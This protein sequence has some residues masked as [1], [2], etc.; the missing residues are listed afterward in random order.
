[1]EINR[2]AAYALI[3]ELTKSE[4]NVIFSD[5][6]VIRKLV[7]IREKPENNLI[8]K[9][10]ILPFTILINNRFQS[11][12]Q[13]YER[14][15]DPE[16]PPYLEDLRDK[17]ISE[18]DF[19]INLRLG[20]WDILNYLTHLEFELKEIRDKYKINREEIVLEANEELN[21][22]K[23]YETILDL[24]TTCENS[25]IEI[26]YKSETEK[27]TPPDM[28]DIHYVTF[29][30][31]RYWEIHLPII[32]RLIRLLQQRT[33]IIEKTDDYVH[34]INSLSSQPT[35]QWTKSDTDLLELIISLHEVGAIQNATKDLSQ[36]EAIQM[37]SDFFGKE[38]KDQYKKLNAA[39]NRKKEDPGFVNKMQKALEA[40]Y[41]CLNERM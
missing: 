13:E 27:G 21:K 2:S 38:M 25:N 14:E 37:I 4:V 5:R 31:T 3:N 15:I 34:K 23:D 8:D 10:L 32:D 11:S 29:A 22:D 19:N 7:L 24:L 26:K 41:Q 18:I 12:H 28:N 16:Y 39:R 20:K 17:L 9:K 36:K 30:L 6:R 35:L 33:S 40:Y 1:M